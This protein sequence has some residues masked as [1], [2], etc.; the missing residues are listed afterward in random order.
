MA[1]KK[2]WL[3]YVIWAVFTCITGVM[4]ADYTILFWTKEINSKAGFGTI[5]L[6]AGV[7]VAVVGIYLFFHKVIFRLAQNWNASRKTMLFLEGVIV[8]IALLGGLAYRIFLCMQTSTDTIT[9]TVYYE[10]AMLKT[11]A[12]SEPMIH[13]AS[14]LYTLCL[15]F[16][17]SFLGNKT[18]A[19]VWLQI[20]F[21][22]LAL[23]LTYIVVRKMIGKIAACVTLMMLAVSSVY[24]KQIFALTPESFYFVFYLAGMLVVG[25]FVRN[26][27]RYCLH[28]QKMIV[29]AVVTGVVMGGLLYL[30]ATAVSLFILLG[31]ILT[32]IH[33]QE[34]GENAFRI[35]FS[36][37]L[38]VIAV[39]TAILFFGFFLAIDAVLSHTTF[40]AVAQAWFSLYQSY[41]SMGYILYQ[42]RISIA[43]CLIQVM[44]AALL[45][46]GF[47]NHS[48]EQNCTPYLCM[49]F[50]LAPTPLAISGVL[51]YQVFSIFLWSI[52]AGIGLQQCFV[53]EKTTVIQ[54]QS[55]REETIVSVQTDI[56]VTQEAPES[57]I[58]IPQEAE[59]RQLPK[60]RFLVNPLPLPKKHEKRVMDYQYSVTEEKMKFDTD[61]KENDDFDI[62]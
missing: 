38:F 34:E 35:R 52:L 11:G 31:G 24:V 49:M 20:V 15:S 5:A 50:L 37:L 28:K 40:T 12:V 61:I 13:G 33:R 4:L 47:W 39:T 16:V 42:T 19:G 55:K 10:Q 26:S 51:S 62:K 27:C 18:I 14:Y 56:P 6:I 29:F 36:F 32:G 7:F 17:L 46:M 25:N 44:F 54:K 53:Q 23:L 58:P 8:V 48:K 30:D 22:M 57:E 1:Y 41:L 9:E 21:Q 60:P 59:P 45:I 3:S 2:T 43:E